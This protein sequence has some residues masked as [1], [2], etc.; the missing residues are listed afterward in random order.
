MVNQHKIM[1]IVIAVC[2]MSVMGVVIDSTQPQEKSNT[3]VPTETSIISDPN[4]P[5]ASSKYSQ[6]ESDFS[7]NVSGDMH[8]K[9]FITISGM[10]P[11]KPDHLTGTVRMGQGADLTILYVFQIELDENENRYDEKVGI[12]DD[13]L[14]K[15]DTVYTISVNHGGVFKEMEFY[16]GTVVNNFEDSIVPCNNQDCV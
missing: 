13:Y 16:R 11:N 14:W 8:D 4:T 9:S 6:P 12:N 7:I 10:I 5:Y 15:E 3:S 1:M 2:V